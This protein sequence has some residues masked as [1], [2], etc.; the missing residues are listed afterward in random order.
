MRLFDEQETTADN[1]TGN[2]LL[3]VHEFGS[4]AAKAAQKEGGRG[5]DSGGGS[6]S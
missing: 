3:I 6:I 2:I 5:E 4:M 1:Y